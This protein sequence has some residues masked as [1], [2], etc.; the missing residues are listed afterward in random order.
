MERCNQHIKTYFSSLLTKKK[1]KK[2][3]VFLS[4]HDVCQLG[5]W[6]WCLYRFVSPVRFH[7]RIIKIISKG[8]RT[9]SR[10][11]F[12]HWACFTHLLRFFGYN[13]KSFPFGIWR[14]KSE[15]EREKQK[16]KSL[17][18]FSVKS[19]PSHAWP[20]TYK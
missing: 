12:W 3:D 20:G 1:E 16:L 2:F 19:N 18:L 6:W 17:S 10:N 13:L 4:L 14:R 9:T 11:Q 7:A 5:V 15:R 8:N